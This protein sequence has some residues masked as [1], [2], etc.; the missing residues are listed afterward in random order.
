MRPALAAIAF[1]VVL[2]VAGGLFDAEPLFVGG[3]ALPVLAVGALAWVRLAAAGASIDR[4]VGALRI[5]ED[6]PLSVRIDVRAPLPL[7]GGAIDDELLP[8]AVA[9]RGGARRSRLRIEVRFDRR[10]RRHLSPPVLTVADP[11]GL[12]RREVVGG[13]VAEVLVLPRT[14]PVRAPAGGKPRAGGRRRAM[15]ESAADADIDGLRAYRL[16]APASRIHWPALARG[17]GLLERRMRPDADSRPLV[18]LDAR[19]GTSDALDA[20]VRAAAS[21]CL[22]LA[23]AGGCAVALPGDRR[24]TQVE[25]ELGAWAGV[26]ARLAVVEPGGGPPGR[27]LAGR[28]G[29]VLYVAPAWSARIGRAMAHAS[30]TPIV[31]LPAGARETGGGRPAFEV[32]GCRGYALSRAARAAVA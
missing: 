7:P 16:G 28:T 6:E 19:G 31:V 27:N 14:E 5:V 3:V 21:L 15:V 22:E 12:A 23:R 13:D 17:A 2:V 4:E 32:A 20:A 25:R 9:I 24:A 1:G 18:L 29:P 26:W 30:G 8:G 11:L 10:G